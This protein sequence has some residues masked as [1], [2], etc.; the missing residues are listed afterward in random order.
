MK[1]LKRDFELSENAI[2]GLII[3]VG[4]IIRTVKT[5]V[6]NRDVFVIMATSIQEPEEDLSEQELLRLRRRL[7][8]GETDLPEV[9]QDEG[10]GRRRIGR[11]EAFI[12]LANAVPN[13]L[14]LLAESDIEIL[15]THKT[16][17]EIEGLF[18]RILSEK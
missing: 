1:K 14:K 15:S 17:S 10:E 4:E 18:R 16:N 13:P 7:G 2:D 12:Q 3:Q 9:F 11:R 8:V 6:R 5:P